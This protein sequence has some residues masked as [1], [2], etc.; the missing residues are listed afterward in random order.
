[1]YRL[2][3]SAGGHELPAMGSSDELSLVQQVRYAVMSK[4]NPSSSFSASSSASA[5]AMVTDN[6][7]GV[8]EDDK[9]VA[10]AEAEYCDAMEAEEAEEVEKEE[11]EEDDAQPRTRRGP[12]KRSRDEILQQNILLRNQVCASL[13]IRLYTFLHKYSSTYTYLPQCLLI[14]AHSCGIC[15]RSIECWSRRYKCWSRGTLAQ[16]SSLLSSGR[17]R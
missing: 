5:I 7:D 15:K 4:C 10:A 6:N 13:L 8:V 16:S 9:D 17:A 2:G 11:E 3:R 14:N 12:K 1:M